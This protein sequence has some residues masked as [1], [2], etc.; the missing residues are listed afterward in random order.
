MA[1]PKEVPLIEH[2]P[3]AATAP[4]CC[5]HKTVLIPFDVLGKN[6][7]E[8]YWGGH[9]WRKSYGRRSRIEAVFAGLKS[10]HTGRVKRGWAQQTGLA[11]TTLGVAVAVIAHNIRA[12]QAWA[13]KHNNG[14][15]LH[16]L[17]PSRNNTKEET[18]M[19]PPRKRPPTT[20]KP[21]QVNVGRPDRSAPTRS[22][23]IGH[24][25]DSLVRPHQR[26]Q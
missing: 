1:Y 7:Q 21:R 9:A 13:V 17:I 19:T 22:A 11:K 4:A 23:R 6:Y 26:P 16:P 5:T 10:P 12:T 8:H 20:G 24:Q 14:N 2:P 25:L 15:T 18:I 3:T